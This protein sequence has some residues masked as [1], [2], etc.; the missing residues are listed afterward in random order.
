MLKGIESKGMLLAAS[1]EDHTNVILLAPES[2]I[3]PGSKIS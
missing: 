3:E 2:D 1:N